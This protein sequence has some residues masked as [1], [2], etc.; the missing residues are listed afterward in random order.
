[1]ANKLRRRLQKNKLLSSTLELTFPHLFSC[2]SFPFFTHRRPTREKRFTCLITHSLCDR[3]GDES[4]KGKKWIKTVEKSLK[5]YRFPGHSVLSISRG[6]EEEW[7]SFGVQQ[8]K[9][10]FAMKNTRERREQK[11]KKVR[12][13]NKFEYD[14][15]IRGEDFNCN[16]MEKC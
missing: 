11:R 9:P 2:F 6:G 1:M 3:G 12:K 10:R 7:K 13:R 8:Q 14:N 5:I 4:R 16:L 15:W